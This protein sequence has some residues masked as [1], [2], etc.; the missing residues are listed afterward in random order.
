MWQWS[1]TKSVFCK[2]K[3][4]FLTR[5]SRP[6]T[7]NKPTARFS[8][9]RLLQASKAQIASTDPYRSV[10][11]QLKSAL[12]MC[13]SLGNLELRRATWEATPAAILE[14]VIAA[15]AVHRVSMCTLVLL[16]EH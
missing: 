13:F 10:S 3:L 7:C 15:E 12:E 14:R 1:A 4:A 6:I 9:L 2:Y 8:G 16:T 5:E 11:T